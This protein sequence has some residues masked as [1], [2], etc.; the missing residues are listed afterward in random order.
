MTKGKKFEE[1]VADF[2]N[3]RHIGGPGEPDYRRGSVE[4]EA[5]DWDKRMGKSDVKEEA[6]KG[7]GE[8]VSKQGFTDEAVDYKNRYRSKVKLFDWKRKKYI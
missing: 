5:K 4:G 1:K 7:R 3:G 8:I 2:M 6:D